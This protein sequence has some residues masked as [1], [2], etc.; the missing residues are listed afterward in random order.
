MNSGLLAIYV[1][2]ALIFLICDTRN[3]LVQKLLSYGA[4]IV[5]VVASIALMGW[6]WAWIPFVLLIV[7]GGL[8]GGLLRGMILRSKD[9]S[10]A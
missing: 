4:L 9:K 10:D 6:V 7:V 1:I 3:S 5:S 2:S 8:L